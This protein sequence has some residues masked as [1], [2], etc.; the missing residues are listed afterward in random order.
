MDTA[1]PG[2]GARLRAGGHT[3]WV[4]Q[5]RIGGR[6]RR[7]TIGLVSAIKATDARATA[8]R[9]YARVK[10]GQDPSAVKE[11]ALA[12]QDETVG[13]TID[14]YL[15]RQRERLRPRSF[16]GT[17]RHLLTHAKPLHHLPLTAVDRRAI[18]R[19]IAGLGVSRGP[20][21]ANDTL[22]DLCALYAWAVREGLADTNPAAGANRFPERSRERTLSDAEISAVWRATASDDPYSAL[23]RLLM[24]T[25][26]RREE[27]GALRWDEVDLDARTI[28]LPPARTK[29]NRPHV[30]PLSDRAFA[31][32]DAQPRDSEH[33]FGPGGFSSWSRGK[34]DL[35]AR[36][37]TAGWRLHDL[38]RTLSTRLHEDLL[39]P[40]HL[41]EAT[42]G[43]AIGGIASVYNRS[44]YISER[45]RV[46]EM[47]SEHLASI[48]E[49]RPAKAN[50]VALTRPAQ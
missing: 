20:S 41:I 40:P 4:F 31:I 38:R 47:W 37:G 50:V 11:A 44:S 24:L 15:E 28:S 5:F 2:Y 39:Q 12:A 19:L 25:G 33:V 6:Q 3:S 18:A 36:S 29:N 22:K 43:H 35:D 46:L 45:R 9:F 26:A 8:S 23:V 14:G 17:R 1:V 7:I 21:A 42:L 13:A 30:I 34:A 27:L 10:L 16:D 32:V 49:G 48:V